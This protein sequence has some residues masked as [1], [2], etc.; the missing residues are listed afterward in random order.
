[1]KKIHRLKNYGKAVAGSA[2]LVGA[3]LTG[4]GFAAAQGGSSGNGYTLGDFPQPFVSEDGTVDSTIVVG[5]NA[6]TVDVVGAVNI[7]GALGNTAFKEEPANG[8]FSV[9]GVDL[10]GAIRSGPSSV[11]MDAS[12]YSRLVRKSV[13]EE[14]G[15]EHFV[16]EKASLNGANVDTEVTNTSE[17]LT[18]ASTGALKYS[19]SY[20]PAF[21]DGDSVTVLGNDY[22]ITEVNPGASPQT[23]KL[24]STKNRENMAV[25]DSYDH[26]PYTVEVTDADEDNSAIFIR[27]SKGETVLKSQAMDADG[28]SSDG[29]PS[30]FTV[31]S[32]KFEVEAQQIFFGQ[33]DHITLKT[34]WTNNVLEEGE[35]LPF[36]SGYTVDQ[37]QFNSSD[38]GS[39]IQKLEFSSQ[40]TTSANPDETDDEH[41]VPRLG[42]GD[43]LEGPESYFNLTYQGLEDAATGDI[44]FG[45]DTKTTFSDVSGFS[46]TVNV[47]SNLVDGTFTSDSSTTRVTGVKESGNRYPVQVTGVNVGEAT[48]SIDLKYQEFNRKLEADASNAQ[49]GTATGQTAV[50]KNDDTSST[51]QYAT[52]AAADDI[53]S[54]TSVSQMIEY[55]IESTQDNMISSGSSGYYGANNFDSFSSSEIQYDSVTVTGATFDMNVSESATVTVDIHAGGTGTTPIASQS[56]SD[57]NPGGDTDSWY[58]ANVR[59]ADF[60]DASGVDLSGQSS[61]QVQINTDSNGPAY[62]DTNPTGTTNGEGADP[63]IAPDMQ[64]HLQN[65]DSSGAQTGDTFNVL[66]FS[67]NNLADPSNQSMSFQVAESGSDAYLTKTAETGY[68][69]TIDAEFIDSGDDGNFDRITLNSEPVLHTQHG[70]VISSPSSSTVRVT[71]GN[72]DTIDVSYSSGNIQSVATTN[73]GESVPDLTSTGSQTR[74]NYGS[75]VKFSGDTSASIKYPEEQLNTQYAFGSVTS[76]SGETIKSPAGWPDAAALDSEISASER[77]SENLILV[78]GPIVNDLTQELASEGKT[79]NRTQYSNNRGVGVIDLVNDAF[80]DGQTAL[81]VA[82]W[83]GEDTRRASTFLS[84]YEEHQDALEGSRVKVDT[85][86]GEVVQ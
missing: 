37:I 7:A 2:L 55:Q 16:V 84:N 60:T 1:M 72:G 11:T 70:A 64:V 41:D 12:D 68:G 19:V 4:A 15:S 30:S 62:V 49:T 10:E 74:T 43:A 36:D 13:E 59:P 51:P 33:E 50:Q 17:V 35:T 40:V 86:T 21:T 54:G 58:V 20:T 14:D 24:G 3:T 48:S 61:L 44:K 82:G 46:H 75:V 29:T 42:E 78:G 28:D 47:G 34:T 6:K 53:P 56:Y 73:S 57:P 66:Q 27:V 8:G 76:G 9:D 31:D 69:F 83:Q 23:V 26:G 52:E 79:W 25:G 63:S 65:V 67:G 81:V 38:S 77:E 85:E 39:G 71:E 32:K 22:E 18:T 80:A 5:E 45:G